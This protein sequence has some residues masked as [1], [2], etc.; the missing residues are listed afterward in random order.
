MAALAVTVVSLGAVA[1]LAVSQGAGLAGSLKRAPQGDGSVENVASLAGADL[2]EPFDP[3]LRDG[4]DDPTVPDRVEEESRDFGVAVLATELPAG[5]VM[6]VDGQRLDTPLHA[7]TEI[8][9]PLGTRSILVRADGYQPWRREVEVGSNGLEL[10]P[11]LERERSPAGRPATGRVLRVQP[12]RE[13]SGEMVGHL[14]QLLEQGKMLYRVQRYG[15]ALESLDE[16]LDQTTAALK[17]YSSSDSL[18]VLI[19]EAEEWLMKTRKECEV[20]K[21]PSCP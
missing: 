8:Q 19:K 9:L 10:K 3:A 15:D 11:S 18:T 14:R 1:A 17:E 12:A 16:V 21:D 6:E 2:L 7:G 13:P 4:V 20:L 5:A